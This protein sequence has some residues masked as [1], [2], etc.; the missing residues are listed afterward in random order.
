[1]HPTV[2]DDRSRNVTVAARSST[3]SSPSYFEAEL[4]KVEGPLHDWKMLW[5]K[6]TAQER[7]DIVAALFSEVRVR[8]KNVV[9]A[10][11]ADPTYAPPIA[12]SEARRVW[13]VAPAGDGEEQVGL[14]PPDGFEPPTR[15]LGRCRSIH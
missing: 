7:Q 5:D 3:S 15:S 4:V 10:T 9:S 8:D 14:A 6:A 13:L 12:S 2:R 1:M 11:L